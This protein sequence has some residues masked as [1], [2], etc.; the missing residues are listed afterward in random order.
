MSIEP[1]SCSQSETEVTI[2][3]QS[4]VMGDSAASDGSAPSASLID[5]QRED[6]RLVDLPKRLIE[7]GEV[8]GKGGMGVVR[9]AHQHLPERD[10]AVKNEH[11]TSFQNPFSG[12]VKYFISFEVGGV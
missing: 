2:T 7:V 11:I 8:I 9:I 5:L 6:V 3:Y 1:T 12:S 10:V 4:S